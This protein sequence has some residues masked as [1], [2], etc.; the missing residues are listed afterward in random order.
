MKAD[1]VSISLANEIPM[2]QVHRFIYNQ[3][4]TRLSDHLPNKKNVASSYNKSLY[5]VAWK[6]DEMA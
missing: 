5:L 3:L 6:P 1:S 4:S 2:H